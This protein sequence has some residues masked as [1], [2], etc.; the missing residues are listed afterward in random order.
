ME[1]GLGKRVEERGDGV[2]ASE[3][4]NVD[5]S[6]LARVAN[7][8][9]S[10]IKAYSS[11]SYPSSSSYKPSYPS[12][13][14]T[15]TKRYN[16]SHRQQ[17][18]KSQHFNVVLLLLCAADNEGAYTKAAHMKEAYT[19]E[20]CTHIRRKVMDV[21]STMRGRIRSDDRL[22][23]SSYN[24]H[25]SY[26]SSYNS[27]TN[28]D[29]NSDSDS[30][31]DSGYTAISD[32]SHSDMYRTLEIDNVNSNNNRADRLDGV[33]RVDGGDKAI[34]VVQ[35][36]PTTFTI[37]ELTRYSRKV[38]NPLLAY[39][40]I[41]WGLDHNVFTPM[42]IISDAISLLYRYDFFSFLYLIKL[43]L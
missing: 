37:A 41:C 11:S 17:L 40:V 10:L 39:E 33:D 31:S 28:S 36:V 3:Y 29:N 32:M 4:R 16:N 38:N 21:Y 19:K 5:Y 22:R 1:Q 6:D 8:S 7:V 24:S 42:G 26:N 18:L 23:N 34:R 35:W 20:D 15:G 2:A 14:S 30:D 13:D 9:F 12:F 43:D 27:T 25:I